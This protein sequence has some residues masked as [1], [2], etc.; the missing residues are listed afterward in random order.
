MSVFQSILLGI[1]QGLC[2]FLPVSSSG[3][4]VLA[5]NLLGV[6]E[7]GLLF[8]TLLH[9]GTLAAV[10]AVYYRD[11]WE[12]IRHPIRSDLRY[13]VLATI[14]AVA[15]TL[16]FGDFFDA[17]FA[18]RFLGVSFLAT[19]VILYAGS[20]CHGHQTQIQVKNSLLMGVWQ[21]VAILPGVSRSGS[22]IS[23]GMFAGLTRERAARFSFLMSIPA[24]CGSLVFQAK[25]ILS[26]EALGEMGFLAV[27]A[28]MIAAAVTGYLAIRFMLRLLQKKSLNGF[29]LYTLVL[30]V[31]VLSDQ[32]FFHIFF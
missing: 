27:A 13:L 11:I 19:S 9:V 32:L 18:G 6:S 17:A 8:N 29:A 3:H 5:Q 7:G 22:T 10:F 28:G 30:G 15:A 23:G 4:L 12:M 24:I 20:K 21:A 14:P 16:L 1:I 26:G 31:L 25:D 2:E